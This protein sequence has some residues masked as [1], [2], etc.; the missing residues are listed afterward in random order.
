MQ[1]LYRRQSNYIKYLQ[2]KKYLD[3]KES[4]LELCGI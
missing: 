2:D 4:K 1:H 3:T